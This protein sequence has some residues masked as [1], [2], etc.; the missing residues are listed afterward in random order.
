[1]MYVQPLFSLSVAKGISVMWKNNNYFPSCSHDIKKNKIGRPVWQTEF[2]SLLKSFMFY[3]LHNAMV[4]RSWGFWYPQHLYLLC[5]LID[6]ASLM[7]GRIFQTWDMLAL[8]WRPACWGPSQFWSYNLL[9]L[10][11]VCKFSLVDGISTVMPETLYVHLFWL[12]GSAWL[13]RSYT[14][15]EGFQIFSTSGDQNETIFLQTSFKIKR[16]KQSFVTI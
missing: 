8:I 14:R 12:L 9:V 4:W 13:F 2:F 16:N 5:H 1:M 3:I 15:N 10:G 7:K 11:F 6:L